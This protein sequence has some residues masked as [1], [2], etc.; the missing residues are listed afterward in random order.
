MTTYRTANLSLFALIF[1]LL[2]SSCTNSKKA[3]YSGNYDNTIN[4]AVK[5]LRNGKNKEK[6][7][8]LLEEAFAK[9]NQRDLGNIAAMKAGG[10]PDKWLKVYYAYT[11]I[12]HRQNK[13]RP[14][15][16]LYIKSERRTANI[17]PNNFNNQD[18]VVAKR[19]AAEFL[20]AAA[21]QNLESGYKL[22]AREAFGQLEELKA[23]FPSFRDVDTQLSRARNAGTNHV[24][25]KAVNRSGMVMPFNFEQELM[26]VP[27]HKLNE[28]WVQYYAEPMRGIDFDYDVVVNLQQV[29]VSPEAI[30]ENRFRETKTIK[31]GW[32][33]VLDASGNVKKDSLGNDIKVD[34]YVDV[35]CDVV[36]ISQ[37]KVARI[38]GTVQY[39][40]RQNRQ[41][42]EQFPIST[43]A[44][45]DNNYVTFTGN[46][47]ALSSRV[48][49]LCDNGIAPFPTDMELL[50]EANFQLKDIVREV[51]HDHRRV[52]AAVN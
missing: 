10:N 43:D 9:A 11:N 49:G 3:M 22:N 33:Y 37:S 14:L 39:F 15:L 6:Q 36:E 23:I 34:R 28:N 2:V 21:M 51:L 7:I 29:D 19:N 42:M 1:V 4:I 20:Y 38:A 44:I 16:P 8:I 25:I 52:L 45:F 26:R 40:N 41:M 17:N 47:R 18:Y 13:V 27:T 32:D 5:K 35:Y 12:L 50:T 24:L 48:R 31:D 30:R 46:R